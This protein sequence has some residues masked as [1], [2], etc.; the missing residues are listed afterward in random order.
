M[1]VYEQGHGPVPKGMVV[2]FKDGDK[3]NCE[4]DNLML[5]SKA[6]LLNLNQKG[7]KDLP[8]DLKP[9]VLALAKLQVKTFEK[10]KSL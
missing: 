1:H 4:P 6:E 2:S 8:A 9:S 10:A 5:I 7:Y 3:T